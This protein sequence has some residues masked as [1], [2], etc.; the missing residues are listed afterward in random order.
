MYHSAVPAPIPYWGRI[1]KKSVRRNSCRPPRVCFRAGFKIHR[2]IG[3][4]HPVR[5][6]LA[7]YIRPGDGA[8]GVTAHGYLVDQVG[9]DTYTSPS[10]MLT[11]RPLPQSRVFSM[12][13]PISPV[14]RQLHRLNRSSPDFNKQFCNLL[15]GGEYVQSVPT[16][17]GEDSAWLAN[18]LDEVRHSRHPSHS[19]LKLV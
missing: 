12:G 17:Q 9:S 16:L 15:S 7:H 14:L 4:V 11:R 13:S 2:P 18:Y 1:P 10:A 5:P 8:S 19:P 3:C 6:H